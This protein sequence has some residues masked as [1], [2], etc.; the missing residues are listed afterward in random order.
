[1]PLVCSGGLIGNDR[2]FVTSEECAKVIKRNWDDK[3]GLVNDPVYAKVGGELIMTNNCVM[4]PK[5]GDG[6]SIAVCGLGAAVNPQTVLVPC[7][8]DSEVQSGEVLLSESQTNL[9]NGKMEEKFQ[10]TWLPTHNDIGFKFMTGFSGSG[11]TLCSSESGSPIYREGDIRE[12]IGINLSSNMKCGASLSFG[13]TIRH[14]SWI[15]QECA[16]FETEES[17]FDVLKSPEESCPEEPVEIKLGEDCIKNKIDFSSYNHPELYE[18]S[19]NCKWNIVAPK[20]HQVLME[21][22][23]VDIERSNHKRKCTHDVLLWKIE[24]RPN[25]EICSSQPVRLK[26]ISPKDSVSLEFISDDS[27]KGRGFKAELSCQRKAPMNKN[28]G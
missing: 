9:N 3:N 22:V 23:D 2:C 5:V 21:F 10:S 27:F 16:K 18:N 28:R 19:Q 17:N 13:N 6:D 25:I 8:P 14:A 15:A 4:S 20:G 26:Y 1:M 24:G 12:L 7:Y 11:Q